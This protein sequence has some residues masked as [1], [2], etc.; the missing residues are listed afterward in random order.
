MIGELQISSL[1]ELGSIHLGPA[2]TNQP[3]SIDAGVH[4]LRAATAGD[5]AP[6]TVPAGWTVASTDVRGRLP[7]TG[8]GVSSPPGDFNA[9]LLRYQHTQVIDTAVLLAQEVVLDGDV[10]VLSD[11]VTQLIIVADTIRSANGST[12]KWFGAGTTADPVASPPQAP[13]GTP[14]YLPD[15]GT[16]GTFQRQNGGDG[17]DGT[18]GRTG[19]HGITA[20]DVVVYLKQFTLEPNST[21]SG[22]VYQPSLPAVD[23]R[24]Q[25]GGKGQKGQRGGDGGH[26]AKGRK[27]IN[28]NFGDCR[29]GPG[30]G[31]HG[32]PGGDGGDGGRGGNGGSG[33][34]IVI[35]YVKPP[36]DTNMHT[37]S[38]L[39]GGGAAGAG[40]AAGLGGNGGKGGEAG[41]RS[42]N[43]RARPER[44]GDDGQPGE[45][46]E[47]GPAGAAGAIGSALFEE[48]P[49]A[50]WEAAFT[51]PYLVRAA[52]AHVGDTVVFET[53]NLSGPASL[54]AT[55][56]LTGAQRAFT[57]EQVAED[58]YSWTLP[59]SLE[60]TAYAVTLRRAHDGRE[61]NSYR[62]EV[63]PRIDAISFDDEWDARPGG[64]ARVIG[65]GL[66]SDVDVIYDGERIRPNRTDK[67]VEFGEPGA[68][69]YRDVI[70]F[71]IPVG[72]T[73]GKYFSRDTGVTPHTVYLDQPYP[74]A[75][76]DQ[77]TL[78]L[79]RTEGM[80]FLA[81]VNG[82]EFE[83]KDMF[84]AAR[85]YVTQGDYSAGGTLKAFYGSDGFG[86]RAYE[87]FRE[88]YG[89][90]EVDGLGGLVSPFVWA[91]FGLWYNYWSS[92]EQ[93]G[94]GT[95]FALSTLSLHDFF[96]GVPTQKDKT[97][98]DRVRGVCVHHE[99][100]VSDE[101][102]RLQVA[103]TLL[104][105]V[106][107]SVNGPSMT[108][109]AVR[110]M[111]GFFG[112]AKDEEGERYAP[113]MLF[114]PS[115]GAYGD[116]LQQAANLI[117]ESINAWDDISPQQAWNDLDAGYHTMT[118]AFKRGHAVTPY[119]VVYEEPG[120]SLPSRVYFYD[121]NEPGRDD[122][123]LDIYREGGRVKFK[124]AGKYGSD[125]DQA[126]DTPGGF[127]L[128]VVP[129]GM[130][131]G[132]VDLLFDQDLLAPN[133]GL[134]ATGA[135][136]ETV[137][138]MLDA[139]KFLGA[140]PG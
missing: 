63:L 1:N 82:F 21:S 138:A 51:A 99:R 105:G 100:Q 62:V 85:E 81:S 19:N 38:F 87:L 129:V 45:A 54:R 24:G 119:R 137:A 111:A 90:G 74:L 84:A 122:V 46:G 120:D 40:G 127:M 36:A 113:I 66:R 50:E 89:A 112:H 83:N 71:T 56:E 121:N 102:M 109:I 94:T 103:E 124:Y 6:P 58:T 106:A 59:E 116:V 34:H 5:F 43:C 125:P 128:G 20:P 70:E 65:L 12:I 60:S 132:D 95:C 2:A 92:P 26:G 73:Q 29:S 4:V 10:M 77:T 134:T 118:R 44:R 98:G 55:D 28:G 61:T 41:N 101:I 22:H 133:L 67:H 31:G 49:L 110:Y 8:G 135:I 76:S 114:L 68:P 79:K 35:H 117:G 96:K 18:A 140:L 64:K 32:G 15:D 130:P 53:L 16:G 104:D 27:A 108:E 136:Y 91:N 93:G 9:R 75:D 48:M 33:G 37:A 107:P 126:S 72:A 13:Q 47:A 57:M 7:R 25:K 88:T 123:Y 23:V 11:N 115:F 52:D 139:S 86:G 39:T 131:L 30:Y 14:T 3:L 17:P 69:V 42:S 80:T 97:I 78:T